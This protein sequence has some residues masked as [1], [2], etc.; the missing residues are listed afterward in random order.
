MT[1]STNPMNSSQLPPVALAFV[2]D[3]E[4]VLLMNTSEKMAA[5][6]QSDPVVVPYTQ[7]GTETDPHPGDTWDGTSFT[8]KSE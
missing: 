7:T 1:T 3:G 6:L 4:V 8:K 5:V 2:I